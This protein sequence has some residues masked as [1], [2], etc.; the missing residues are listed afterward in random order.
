MKRVDFLSNKKKS[1][2][3]PYEPINNGNIKI[4]VNDKQAP[5]VQSMK[6]HAST[7]NG[8]IRA[9]I[10]QFRMDPGAHPIVGADG[11]V[12]TDEINPKMEDSMILERIVDDGK[13]TNFYLRTII[14][15]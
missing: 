14:N 4:Y 3:Y 1:K 12:A 9:S 2:V 15:A 6:L 5:Y 11:F 7:S 13:F 10:T 8:F